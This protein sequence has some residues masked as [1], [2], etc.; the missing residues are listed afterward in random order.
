MS[1]P[2]SEA[3]LTQFL[4]DSRVRADTAL[5]NWAL[6]QAANVQSV[7]IPLFQDLTA[8]GMER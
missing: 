7:T 1:I 5:A 3:R 6:D 2:P 4:H 8:A